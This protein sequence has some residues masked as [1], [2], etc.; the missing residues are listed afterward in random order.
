MAIFVFHRYRI[1]TFGPRPSSVATCPVCPGDHDAQGVCHL[2]A[3]DVCPGYNGSGHV[4]PRDDTA[5][6]RNAEAGDAEAI[7]VPGGSCG[8]GCGASR[9]EDRSASIHSPA[10]GD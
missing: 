9:G 1:D 7:G 2:H 4:Y 10:A 5:E 6:G 8:S 3:S